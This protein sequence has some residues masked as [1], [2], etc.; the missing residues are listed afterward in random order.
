MSPKRFLLQAE[1]M[2]EAGLDMKWMRLWVFRSNYELIQA[3]T[4]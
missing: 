1:D 4:E 2:N 3:G